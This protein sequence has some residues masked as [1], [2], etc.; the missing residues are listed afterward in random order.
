MN[1]PAA[2]FVMGSIFVSISGDRADRVTRW[3]A[4]QKEKTRTRLLRATAESIRARGL[5]ATT[6]SGVSAAIGMTHGRSC[7]HLASRDELVSASIQEMFSRRLLRSS[8]PEFYP[9]R[10]A[11]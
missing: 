7:A 3:D 10:R 8:L 5:A 6:I 11:P 4:G 1:A 9:V 2:D